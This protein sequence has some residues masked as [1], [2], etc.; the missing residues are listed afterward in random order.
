MS[1]FAHMRRMILPLAVVVAV[2]AIA[3]PTCQMIG[4]DMEMG[5]DAVRAVQRSSHGG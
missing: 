1:V 2:V 4:C 3:V 5:G